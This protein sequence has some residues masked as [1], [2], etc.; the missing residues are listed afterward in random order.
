MINY[1]ARDEANHNNLILNIPQDSLKD[2]DAKTDIRI[3][4]TGGSIYS[5]YGVELAAFSDVKVVNI[6]GNFTNI[7][8]TIN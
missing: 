8:A 6:I 1:V 7:E 5:E 2:Y 3:T 4:F